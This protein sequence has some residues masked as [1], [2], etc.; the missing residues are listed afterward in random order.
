MNITVYTS[1]SKR[2]NST[3]QPTGGTSVTCDIKHTN[4]MRQPIFH[5]NKDDLTGGIT[6]ESIKYVK[7]TDHSIYYYV[8][9]VEYVPNKFYAL[10]CTIDPMATYKS[11]ITGS[12]QYVLYSASSYLPYIPDPRIPHEA[13]VF[14]RQIP[15]GNTYFVTPPY[16][17]YMLTTLADDPTPGN[18]GGR[19][20]T[21]YAIEYGDVVDLAKEFIDTDFSNVFS[22][23]LADAYDAISSLVYI[24]ISSTNI[25]KG[26]GETK[27]TVYLGNKGMTGVEGWIMD[28]KQCVVQLKDSIV[29]NFT[30][31]DDWRLSSPYTEA[32]VYLPGF[33][34]VELNPLQCAYQLDVEMNIDLFT[35]DCTTYLYGYNEAP[36]PGDVGGL[37]GSYNYHIGIDIPVAQYTGNVMGALGAIAGVATSAVGLA[38]GGPF[39][40]VGAIGMASN[41]GNIFLSAGSK[42]ASIKGSV[43]SSSWYANHPTVELIERCLHVED[44]AQMNATH[45]RPYMKEETLSNLSGYCQ[46]MNASI[47]INGF[48][49]DRDI[50]NGYLNGGFY[51]E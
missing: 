8:D 26:L 4:S 27:K 44:P 9:D 41:V 22:L 23:K 13:E 1:F 25:P 11:S 2:K 15:S 33:G 47:S 45:G 19:F 31:Y 3:K 30:H 46:C 18:S 36:L 14:I 28:S 48:D 10:H 39:G 38:A 24:P 42:T 17:F 34:V 29:C 7:D 20:L 21:T 50:I 37:I 16:G 35:G 32:A 6:P 43:S 12:T 51:I 40:A 49:A 5:I